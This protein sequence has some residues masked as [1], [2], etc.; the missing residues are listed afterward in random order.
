M[1]FLRSLG[2]DQLQGFL[3]SPGVDAEKFESMVRAGTR[4]QL[5]S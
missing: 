3:F 5:D 1:D 2:C 4:L